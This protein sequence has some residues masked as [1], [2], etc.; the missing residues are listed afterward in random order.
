MKKYQNN[1]A[2]NINDC[3]RHAYK[4]N[5]ID[6]NKNSCDTEDSSDNEDNHQINF[7]NDMN[8]IKLLFCQCYAHL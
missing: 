7:L 4:F 8:A 1:Y 3:F 2:L 5:F 6:L